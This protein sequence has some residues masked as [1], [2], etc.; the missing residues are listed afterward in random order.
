MILHAR[1]HVILADESKFGKIGN[2]ALCPVEQASRI[3]STKEAEGPMGEGLR[4]KGVEIIL[5][6]GGESPASASS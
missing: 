2:L 5:F 1:E 4:K 6:E 3:I